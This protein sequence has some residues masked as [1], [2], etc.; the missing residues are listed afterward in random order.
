MKSL[1]VFCLFVCL[2]AI[3]PTVIKKKAV[4]VPQT[5]AFWAHYRLSEDGWPSVTVHLSCATVGYLLFKQPGQEC[6]QHNMVDANLLP[7]KS[8]RQGLQ[9]RAPKHLLLPPAHGVYQPSPWQPPAGYVEKQVINRTAF[10][11]LRWA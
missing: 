2:K 10:C 9:E 5:G 11:L 6:I 8:R 4:I 1:P 3:I 7:V